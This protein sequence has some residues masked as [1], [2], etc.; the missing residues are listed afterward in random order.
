MSE[1]NMQ[2]ILDMTR[3]AKGSFPFRYL[4]LPI[5]SK[6]IKV[7]ECDKILENMC[8][9]IKVWSLRNMSFASRLALVNSVLMTLQTY[10]SQTMVMP[11]RVYKDVNSICRFYEAWDG[12]MGFYVQAKERMRFRP[13]KPANMEYCSNG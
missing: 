13:F 5:C 3:F 9:R 4:G 2:R 1:A 7:G 6:K 8:A 12:S 11:K 10:W